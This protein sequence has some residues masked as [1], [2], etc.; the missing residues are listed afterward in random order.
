MAIEIVSKADLDKGTYA[1]TFN[2]A[3]PFSERA[4][5]PAFLQTLKQPSFGQVWQAEVFAAV[6]LL[7]A[8]VHRCEVPQACAQVYLLLRP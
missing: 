4:S 3:P 6:I 2:D 1:G 7:G 5:D 8:D